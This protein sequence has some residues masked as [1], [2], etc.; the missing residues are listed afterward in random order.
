MVESPMKFR[1]WLGLAF[2]V[3]AQYVI[4]SPYLAGPEGMGFLFLM[5]FGVLFLVL[6][7][8][9]VPPVI[10]LILNRRGIVSKRKSIVLTCL[11]FMVGVGNLISLVF[12]PYLFLGKFIALTSGIGFTYLG[13]YVYSVCKRKRESIE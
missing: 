5:I 12:P 11:T 2:I 1:I 4:A 8:I 7:A 13:Y 9:I 10:A 6:L 3:C